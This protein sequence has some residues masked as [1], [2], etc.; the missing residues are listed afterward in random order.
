MRIVVV[1]AG[2]GG[3]SAACHLAGA[4]H[5][6]VVVE[7]DAHAGGRVM[8]VQE[9]GYTLDLG[10]TVLT[11]TG[12]LADV[13][14]AAGTSLDDHL[15]VKP[16]DPM[17][18]ATFP[19]AGPLRVRQGRE[20]MVEEIRRECG[21]AEADAFV[22][23]CAWLRELYEVE[24]P[25]FIA[26]NFDSVVDL[27]WPLGPIISL[28]RLGGLRRLDKVVSSYF[29]DPRLQKLLSFQA[30]YAGLSPFDA[31]AVYAVITYMDTVEG[32]YYPEGGMSAIG[33]ALADAAIGTG[34]CD[35]R[36]SSPVEA[37][38]PGTR[39]SVRLASGETLIADVVVANPDLPVAYRSLID[40]SADGSVRTPR[41]ARTGE[42][43]PSCALWVAGVQG[44]LPDGAAHHNIHFGGQWREAFDA[45]LK[46]GQRMPDPSIL[47]TSHSYSDPSL[48]PAGGSTLYALEPAPNL[49]GRIDWSRERDGFRASLIER[50]GSFGYPIE[51][52]EAERFLD[53]VDWERMGME[54]GTPFGLSHRFFQSGPFRP[55]NVDKRVP[56][57]V[58]VGS[59]TVPGVGVPMVL[60]SG[61]LAAERV[62]A[63][64]R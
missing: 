36:Y 12:I 10:A 46:D 41:V 2:L 61:R 62:E 44:S 47:V 20:A 25:N 63:I 33:R 23:F 43:S 57:V 59:S 19:D 48:A 28:L 42:Y 9:A 34:R 5:E 39:P 30:M 15:V 49:D 58:F 13:F 37:I 21:A 60:V 29:R 40:E 16:V 52:I 18:R 11:M 24:W 4:G 53:P 7:R 8:A 50:V 17:Y 1:G 38:L 26:R 54:R 31:L 32:V 64:N 14:A 56:G 51:V 35:I 3:L 22:R 55:R 6:V 45:L 27:A